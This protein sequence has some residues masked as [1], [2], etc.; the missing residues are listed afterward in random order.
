MCYLTN[1]SN[2]N[3][4]LDSQRCK[5][6]VSIVADVQAV[7][8]LC[9]ELRN[10]EFVGSNAAKTKKD[11]DRIAQH[12][13]SIQKKL[14]TPCGGEFSVSYYCGRFHQVQSCPAFSLSWGRGVMLDS[15]GARSCFVVEEIKNIVVGLCAM[16]SW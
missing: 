13:F 1:I 9:G 4:T 7:V 16:Y 11:P 15:C 5:R 3:Y 8:D 12:M 10:D 2:T 14:Q 6:A